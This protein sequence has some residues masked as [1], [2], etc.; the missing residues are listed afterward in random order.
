MVN[1]KSQEPAY[2]EFIR[3]IGNDTG[4]ATLQRV[5]IMLRINVSCFF[6]FFLF[7]S[8]RPTNNLSV[9]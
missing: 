9:I 8:L 2:V 6:L 3:A 7:D 1:Y 4:T 5:S